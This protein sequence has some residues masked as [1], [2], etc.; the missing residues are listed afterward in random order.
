MHCQ[1][2]AGHCNFSSSNIAGL[3]WGLTHSNEVEK[4]TTQKE[5]GD[6]E[7]PDE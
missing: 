6:T 1:I 3:V 7:K 2:G 4:V 5:R